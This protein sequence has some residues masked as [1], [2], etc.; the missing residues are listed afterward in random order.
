MNYA[1]LV[2][3]ALSFVP[4]CGGVTQILAEIESAKTDRRLEILENPMREF[5]PDAKPLCQLLYDGIRGETHLTNRVP[6]TGSIAAP[7]E[8]VRRA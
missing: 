8:G 3:I 4:Y 7:S 6:W 5:G 1:A 2:R